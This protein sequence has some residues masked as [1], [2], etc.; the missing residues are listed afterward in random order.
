MPEPTRPAPR[1][2]RFAAGI[3]ANLIVLIPFAMVLGVT[4][5]LVVDL[6][7]AQVLVLPL[8]MLMV[9]PMLVN[10]RVA[11]VAEAGD[12][13]AVGL[14]MAVDFVA[15]PFIAWGL[16][17]AFFADQPGLYVGM[18]LAGLFP[19]SG[20]TISWTG[21]AKGNVAAAIK[22]T[23]IGLLAA[24]ALAPFYLLVLAGAVVEFDLAEVV[25]TVLLVV[26]LPLVLGQITRAAIVRTAGEQALK[27]RVAPVLPGISA[28][29]VLGI[30]F[31]AVGMK[32]PMIGAEPML[33]FKIAVPLLVFYAV[34]FAGS[35]LLGRAT[36]TRGDA[37]ALVY[38]TVMRNLSIALGIAIASFGPDAALVLSGAYIIQVQGAAWYVRYTDRFFG[39]APVPAVA[40][41]GE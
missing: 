29:G 33:L 22:M 3:S 16:A 17:R 14:A 10:F 24:S 20:M 5:G 32:A 7:T 41:V 26:G 12:W 40:P 19:T 37:I 27:Q 18:V 31:L 9:F 34:N 38:G 1:L 2:Q 11:Q 21:M 15:V 8:T 23:V 28:L 30:V 35:T 4:V 6:K 13:K 25:R 36:L 39:T